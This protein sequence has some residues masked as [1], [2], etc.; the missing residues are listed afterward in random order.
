[1]IDFF[2][3]TSLGLFLRLI[4]HSVQNRPSNHSL[5]VGYSFLV[6]TR[7]GC[8]QRSMC[9]SIACSAAALVLMWVGAEPEMRSRVPSG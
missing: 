6:G 9:S 2:D 8:K 7:S 1:M 3:S 5:K 4:T